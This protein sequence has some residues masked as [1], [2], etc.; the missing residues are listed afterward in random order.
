MPE[1]PASPRDDRAFEVRRGNDDAAGADD[2]AREDPAGVGE[3]ASEASRGAPRHRESRSPRSLIGRSRRRRGQPERGM[4]T[5][6]IA[7][8]LGALTFLVVCVTW[9]V[10]VVGMQMRC[11]DAARD[12]ARAAA[13]GEPMAVAEVEALRTAP[14]GADA[15]VSFQAGRVT[16]EVTA[17]AEA[18]WHVLSGIPSIGV[19]GR[20]VVA[21]EPG[22][23]ELGGEAE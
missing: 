22:V 1:V 21:V 11:I 18:P 13:R 20:A 15:E 12:G 7:V 9:L 14:S 10:T 16:V 2:A 8:A 17:D 19:S 5:A 3:A 23:G 4:V 6:E